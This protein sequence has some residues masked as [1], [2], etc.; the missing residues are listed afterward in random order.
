MKMNFKMEILRNMLKDT[1]IL[2]MYK[3]FQW[4]QTSNIQQVQIPLEWMEHVQQELNLKN[5]KT[6]VKLFH[7]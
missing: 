2:N 5:Y 6:Y 1:L 3:S 4:Q 7:L